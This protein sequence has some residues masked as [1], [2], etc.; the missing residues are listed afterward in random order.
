MD[1]WTVDHKNPGNRNCSQNTTLHTPRYDVKLPLNHFYAYSTLRS[2]SIGS[3]SNSNWCH[4]AIYSEA[5]ALW[6]LILNIGLDGCELVT[7]SNGCLSPM[8]YNSV[9]TSNNGNGQLYVVLVKCLPCSFN[10]VSIHLSNHSTGRYS[11]WHTYDWSSIGSG[12][13]VYV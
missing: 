10:C 4:W 13:V 12:V 9:S 8:V 7:G 11:G 2:H 5:F 6:K 1:L 3:H